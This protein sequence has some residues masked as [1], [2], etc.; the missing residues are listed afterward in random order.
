MPRRLRPM[1]CATCGKQ[2]ETQLMRKV[3]CSRECLIQRRRENVP[4]GL[5]RWVKTK[6]RERMLNRNP[7]KDP[8]TR[9]KVSTSLRAMG[10]KPP[11]HGGNGHGPTV[12]ELL[13]ASALG[14][15]NEVA[16][17]TKMSRASGYPT[18]YKVDV[19]HPALK[20]AVEVNGN[21]HCSLR[22]QRSDKKKREFLESRGW[23]V[24][25]FTNR[26]IENNLAAVVEKCLSTISKSTRRTPTSRAGS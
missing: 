11:V 12:H 15:E 1:V 6:G 19:A 10:W 23:K 4:P 18:C 24:L 21:S 7:M 13:L 14:W 16:I 20:I 25:S 3:T 2:F 8:V 9:A 17:P 5:T 22:V 26:E